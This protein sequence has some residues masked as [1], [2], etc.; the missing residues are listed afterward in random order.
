MFG[1]PS[2]SFHV[3]WVPCSSGRYVHIIATKS[4]FLCFVFATPFKCL[5]FNNI[6]EA[7]FLQIIIKLEGSYLSDLRVQKS[8]KTAEWL[9]HG[10]V[11]LFDVILTIVMVI[12]GIKT[13]FLLH[14][15][16]SVMLCGQISTFWPFHANSSIARRV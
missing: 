6:Q 11:Y 3:R 8:S 1:L 15:Q 2:M 9:K 16:I 7:K 5:Y 14:G 10:R 12:S 4:L 13:I